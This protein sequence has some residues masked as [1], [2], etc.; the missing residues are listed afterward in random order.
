MPD[1]TPL[2]DA[3][4]GL[5]DLRRWAEKHLVVADGLRAGKPFKIGG[6]PWADVLDA[7]DD[8]EL[9]QVTIRGSV[10]SE[11]DITLAFRTTTPTSALAQAALDTGEVV[12]PGSA[13]DGAER[14][15]LPRQPHRKG[16]VLLVGE[17]PVDL[18]ARMDGDAFISVRGG[19]HERV[20]MVFRPSAIRLAQ[21]W[22]RVRAFIGIRRQCINSPPSPRA[23]R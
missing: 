20:S 1:G 16:D 12:D 7:M 13:D 6:P 15:G 5:S 19:G 4:R 23:P 3:A 10:Q 17:G 21:G 11:A 2:L 8:P 9:E 22:C 14:H 18:R